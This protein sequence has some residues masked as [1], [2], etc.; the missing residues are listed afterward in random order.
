MKE[1]EGRAKIEAKQKAKMEAEVAQLQEKV[2]LFEAKCIQSIGKAREEG[3]QEVMAMA[4]VME[5]ATANY[6]ALEQEHFK[7]LHNMKEAEERAK[8]EAEQ[9]AMMEAEVA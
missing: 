8:T 2:K 6:T 4:E 9:K 3:K 1:A 5:S 7:V